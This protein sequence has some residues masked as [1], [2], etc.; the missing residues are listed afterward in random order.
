MATKT[1]EG[2]R[3]GYVEQGQHNKQNKGE[4]EEEEKKTNCR[5]L[6]ITCHLLGGGALIL[7]SL[8]AN[9]GPLRSRVRRRSHRWS[10]KTNI[11]SIFFKNT[12]FTY[13][14]YVLQ[15]CLR[16]LFHRTFRSDSTQTISYMGETTRVSR[17]APQGSGPGDRRRSTWLGS[18]HGRV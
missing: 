16:L 18:Q 7:L 13:S 11:Q 8:P 4:E 9:P 10:H 5:P 12:L 3:P 1:P 17:K 15:I 2:E 6:N 14:R